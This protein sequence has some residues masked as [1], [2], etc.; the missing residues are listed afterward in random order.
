MGFSARSWKSSPVALY[1]TA[2]KRDL[3]HLQLKDTRQSAYPQSPQDSYLTTMT[4][5]SLF[6]IT[7]QAFNMDLHLPVLMWRRKKSTLQVW[8]GNSEVH[9]LIRFQYP[10]VKYANWPQAFCRSCGG[11]IR[12]NSLQG[13]SFADGQSFV[14]VVICIWNEFEIKSFSMVCSS[15]YRPGEIIAAPGTTRLLNYGEQASVHC[16]ILYL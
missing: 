13:F 5:S 11:S 16:F 8:N 12:Q 1:S 9:F 4:L 6:S 15:S 7:F 10:A 14:S 2:I 3:D